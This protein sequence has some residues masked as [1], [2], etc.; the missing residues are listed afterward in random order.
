MMGYKTPNTD[1]I[2]KEGALFTKAKNKR[3]IV[4]IGN[5]FQKFF[6]SSINIR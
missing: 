5:K 3:S 6:F 1:R 2:V 4:P